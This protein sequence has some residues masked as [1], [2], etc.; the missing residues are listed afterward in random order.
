M[1][2]FR[3]KPVVITAITFDQLVAHGTE[4]CKA[5]GRES[6]IVNG[7]PWSFSYAGQPITHENDDCYLIPTLEGTMKMG[8]DDML[9]TGVKG[10]IYPCKR[11]IFEATYEAVPDVASNESSHDWRHSS[12]YG[13]QLCADCGA[14]K[15]SRRGGLEC[16]D[17]HAG[18]TPVALPVVDP[19]QDSLEREIQAKASN[20]PSVTTSGIEAEIAREHFFTA[21]QGASHTDAVAKPY[22]FGDTWAS[23]RL[24]A[25][26]FC[27]L[28][29]RN[30]TKVV[31]VNY[32]AID[33]A[34]HSTERGRQD[35]RAQAVGKVYE[36]L[37]FRLRD[38]LARP[39]LTDAD[40]AADLAGTPRPSQA[41]AG[42]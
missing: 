14:V 7:I 1:T 24:D 37:G 5:E 23:S 18:V 20:G 35:A 26:T 10:E 2:Q 41:G 12:S 22:D 9:I 29:L 16:R 25:V 4:R 36:L 30:G 19:G 32:G 28:V 38:E 8:R 34:Q 40:A 17:P 31:G 42:N 11:D 13:G 33:P 21:E 3:K 15:G 6:N 39:V 27:V